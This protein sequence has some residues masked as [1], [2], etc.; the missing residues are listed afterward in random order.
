MLWTLWELVLL[1]KPIMVV[2]DTPAMVSNS[3]LGI[4]SLISPL[5]YVSDYK[6]YMTVYDD[7]FHVIQKSTV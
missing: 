4:I 6:P 2:G 5:E 7:D 1:N 3:V